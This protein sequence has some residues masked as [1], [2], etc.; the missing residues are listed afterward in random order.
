MR[1]E[2]LRLR[3]GHRRQGRGV[4]RCILFNKSD[5]SFAKYQP[6]VARRG[7]KEQIEWGGVGKR[8]KQP[9]P[10]RSSLFSIII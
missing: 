3:P 10:V 2:M 4:S 5:L 8:P 7:K 6:Q 9:P 1:P